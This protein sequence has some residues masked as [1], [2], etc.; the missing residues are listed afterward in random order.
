MEVLQGIAEETK[1][2]ADGALASFVIIQARVLR[3]G[4]RLA[5]RSARCTHT[6]LLLA[7][8]AQA[9]QAAGRVLEACRPERAHARLSSEDGLWA[10][11]G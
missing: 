9:Q 7:G 11:C 8:S 2:M 10:A 3:L 6:A 5:L 4:A 1:A